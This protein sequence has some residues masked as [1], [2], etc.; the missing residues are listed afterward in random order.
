MRKLEAPPLKRGASGTGAYGTVASS[1]VGG[2]DA[3][4][5][6][7]PFAEDGLPSEM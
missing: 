5:R 7:R 1:F 3:G 2:Q 6:G 4:E